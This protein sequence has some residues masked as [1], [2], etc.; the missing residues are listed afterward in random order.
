MKKLHHLNCV[1]VSIPMNDD[2]IGHYLLIE[3]DD[4]LLLID[5]SVGVQDM[6]HPNERLGAELI[7]A[8]GFQLDM[9]LTAFRQIQ[10]Q[11]QLVR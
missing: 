3:G 8:V 2:V 7:E 4:N 9:E 10:R 11:D 1:K 5:T 6:E